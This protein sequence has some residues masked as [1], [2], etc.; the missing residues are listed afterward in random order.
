[1]IVIH[2]TS[3]PGR[4][5]ASGT[6]PNATD[7]TCGAELAVPIRLKAGEAAIHDTMRPHRYSPNDGEIGLEARIF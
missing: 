4:S 2:K 1:M 5:C 7:L 6:G 3:M